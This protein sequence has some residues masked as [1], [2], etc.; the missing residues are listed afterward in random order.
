MFEELVS[1]RSLVVILHQH[2]LY[3]V[4]EL[5]APSLGLESWR[6]VSDTNI[7]LVKIF[8][9]RVISSPWYEE[10]STHGVHIT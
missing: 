8:L 2:R 3:E 6:G 10:Q 1:V 4:L 9:L 7:D 5:A